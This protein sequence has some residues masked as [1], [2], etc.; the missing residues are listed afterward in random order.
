[1]PGKVTLPPSSAILL[2]MFLLISLCAP[3]QTKRGFQPEDIYT[4]KDVSDA[5]ISPDGARV[6]YTVSEVSPD[7]TRYV[8]HLWIVPTA[9]GESKRLTTDEADESTARWSPDGKLIAFYSSRDGQSGL[10]V[11]PAE[12]GQS[13]LVAHVLRTNFFLNKSGESF[14]WSPDS[15]RIAFLSSPEA[16]PNLAKIAVPDAANNPANSAMGGIPERLRRPLTLE[17]INQLPPQIREMILR[18]QGRQAATTTNNPAPTPSAAPAVTPAAVATAPA[19]AAQDDPRVITRLQYKSRTAFSDNLQSHIFIADLLTK[20]VA[21]L[22]DGKYYEHSINWSPKGDEIAF[23]SNHE[24]DPDRVN[25]TDLFVVN[26]TNGAVRQLTK[27]KGCE[28]QPVFSPDGTQIAYL[29]T[30]R[31]VTTIDSVAE[32]TQAFVIS[33]QGGEAKDLSGAIDRRV[34]MVRWLPGSKGIVFAVSSEGQ[35]KVYASVQGTNQLL[36]SEFGTIS[37]FAVTQFEPQQ[38]TY[39][40]IFADEFSGAEVWLQSEDSYRGWTKPL[41]R[42]NESF[43]SQLENTRMLEFKAQSDQLDIQCWLLPPTSLH[44]Q[45]AYLDVPRPE[46]KLADL[47][48]WYRQLRYIRKY[49]NYNENDPDVKKLLLQIEQTHREV[50]NDKNLKKYPVILYIHGGPHGMHGYSFNPTVQALAARGY[51]VLLINPRG[52][53]GYGQKFADGCVNDWGGGDYRDLMR[54]VDEAL[55][56]FPFLDRDRMGV[57]GG[58]YGGYMTNWIVTQ[59]D[60]F[61][62]AIAS[63]SLSN[64]ISFYSTSL[65]QDL[66]H[67]EF[68]GMPWDNYDLLWDRSPLK[69]SKN[70]KTPLLL[71]HGESDNDVHITQAEE[72]YT[73]LRMRGVETVLVRY[74]REG[75]GIR[76][77]QHRVDNLRRVLEWFDGHLK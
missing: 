11:I 10:W 42:H 32:D 72:M 34:S 15:R 24:P 28:W 14:T 8:S 70:A 68:G 4:L 16:H 60:R 23:V 63:A 31:A 59:T 45:S 2:L 57:M 17:E 12:G 22:T 62:A 73:A 3:A 38:R 58:S 54:G 44:T 7:R 69:H 49:S 76:E 33:A 36:T 26:V 52:S 67:A 27:T 43:H 48:K 9:G 75:H 6:V 37:N 19:T 35:A 13:Q 47:I 71:I 77:P 56:K 41:T 55:A 66:I 74:P 65:Y 5:Q 64:L 40:Y 25:N 50:L 30:T 39:A 61:K 51:G 18:A 53:S 21:Q 1:M 20:K 46:E 29:A